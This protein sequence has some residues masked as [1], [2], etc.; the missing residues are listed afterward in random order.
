[1]DE[2][3]F[4]LA[5]Y[6]QAGNYVNGINTIFDRVDTKKYI[7]NGYYQVDFKNIP[8]NNDSYYVLTNIVKNNFSSFYDLLPKSQYFKVISRNKNEGIVNLI[9]NWE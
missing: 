1:M 8:L 5:I 6:N 9:Y 4:G 7:E 3:N 2:F